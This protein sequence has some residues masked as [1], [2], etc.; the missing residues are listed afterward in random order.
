MDSEDE[1]EGLAEMA[2]R[3]GLSLAEYRIKIDSQMQEMERVKAEG[4]LVRNNNGNWNP[5]LTLRPLRRNKKLSSGAA[6]QEYSTFS[7]SKVLWPNDQQKMRNENASRNSEIYGWRITAD[8]RHK[9]TWS[10]SR[11]VA[12]TRIKRNVNGRTRSESRTR[13]EMPWRCLGITNRT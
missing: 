12:G 1:D 11:R 4:K 6:W 13:R 10:G 9:E 3:E 7:D 2:A 5:R 8:D